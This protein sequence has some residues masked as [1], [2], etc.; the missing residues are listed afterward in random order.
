MRISIRTAFTALLLL[1]AII[2]S[3]LASAAEDTQNYYSASTITAE[4]REGINDLCFIPGKENIMAVTVDGFVEIY[5]YGG[6]LRN[7]VSLGGE[8]F[9]LDIM[10]DG[11]EGVIGS[12]AVSGGNSTLYLVNTV[13]G[14][15]KESIVLPYGSIDTVDYSNDGNRFA[16]AT[17][18]GKVSIYDTDAMS[19]IDSVD[20][21]TMAISVCFSP[22]DSSIVCGDK[23]GSIYIYNLSTKILDV[24]EDVHEGPVVDVLWFDENVIISGST[25]GII[26][27]YNRTLATQDELTLHDADI[28]CIAGRREHMISGGMDGRAVIWNLEG[29]EH[30]H[31]LGKAGTDVYSSD[32]HPD[33][34][35]CCFGLSDGTMILVDMDPDEDGFLL[36]ED[37]FPNDISASKDND[38]DGF[39]EVWNQGKGQDDS[40]SGLYLDAFPNRTE[41][42]KDSDDDGFPDEWN[43]LPSSLSYHINQT[44]LALDAFPIDP[45]A[46]KD[47]DGDGYPDE[48]N[49]GWSE[50]EST[51]GLSLD[52]FPK[53]GSDWKDED[54]PMGDGIGDNGDWL[55][56]FNNYV[57]YIIMVLFVVFLVVLVIKISQKRKT[58]FMGTYQFDEEEKKISGF[59]GESKRLQE[60]AQKHI[61]NII[62]N[63]SLTHEI[64]E[65]GFAKV[66]GAK[67][68][69]HGKAAIKMP[70]AVDETLDMS[71]YNKFEREAT[72]WGKLKH[73]NIV[74]FYKSGT[75][76]VPFIAM[77][78]MEGGNL[79]DLIKN[80]HL[81]MESCLKISISLLDAVS[82]AH[83]MATV[84]RDIKP[85]N[86]LFTVDG[87]AK[88]SDWGIGKFMAGGEEGKLKKG[89]KTIS[90]CAPEQLDP[91]KYGD[92]DWS[93]DIFLLGTV[94]YELTAGV[95]P[96]KDK[97]PVVAIQ[98][99]LDKKPEPASDINPKVPVELSR[100]ILKALAKN[101]EDRWRSAD[102]M[103]ET[104]C[105][106]YSETLLE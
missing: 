75:E 76:P 44:G 41:A 39:P 64:G 60:P 35:K 6:S 94:I 12:K 50:K 24:V 89:S 22:D 106:I 68:L 84:H 63:Y 58:R 3:G 1:G 11:T 43:Q 54:W 27:I 23:D 42:S 81:D 32:I 13:T 87:M 101:K 7:S 25:D 20:L 29:R 66:Y 4:N 56:E 49:S 57:F 15:M 52:H 95:H 55:K 61:A 2:L 9:S 83:R 16:A 28:S 82:Y 86:I 59:H 10:N 47:T 65:G 33:G 34:N 62:P 72:I 40:T 85:E 88:I 90:Y 21:Q 14:A 46:S 18:S 92:V 36:E 74:E 105:Q 93:T 100:I 103:Y 37:A 51:T 26:N 67:S 91:E 8:L 53:D 96:F 102:I 70:K 45:S 19:Q 38:D 48:W 77:E 104:I 69:E 80:K 5:N 31:Q 99:V 79:K 78:L 97:D 30:L 73:P 17:R 98:N 71:V